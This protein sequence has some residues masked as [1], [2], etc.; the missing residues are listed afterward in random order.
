M[1]AKSWRMPFAKSQILCQ[2][3]S[4][5]KGSP[6]QRFSSS[7]R[8]SQTHPTSSPPFCHRTPQPVRSRINSSGPKR[9]YLSE[10][11]PSAIHHSRR[12][13]KTWILP[14][15]EGNGIIQMKQV[16][17]QSTPSA[18]SSEKNKESTGVA[19]A[20]STAPQ[21]TERLWA[22]VPVDPVEPPQ[23]KG[24][25][26]SKT[27]AGIDPTWLNLDSQRKRNRFGKAVTY[28]LKMRDAGGREVNGNEEEDFDRALDYYQKTVI[29]SLKKRYKHRR[30][31][32]EPRE[33]GIEDNRDAT[34]AQRRRDG[35]SGGTEER[36][37]GEI[38]KW[39]RSGRKGIDKSMDEWRGVEKHHKSA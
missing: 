14:I 30:R 27:P 19:P 10:A 12:Y 3:T 20:S 31:P 1:P 29:A 17:R 4:P 33:T 21:K 16:L 28:Y 37:E 23:S 35:R 2:R 24:D 13:L 6:P 22:W 38:F 15:L 11:Q 32:R 26:T 7:P 39:L 8:P 9:E 36:P 34:K 18:A 25:P 5:P